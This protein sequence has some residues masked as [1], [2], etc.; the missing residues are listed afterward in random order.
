[1]K[2]K[3]EILNEPEG[4]IFPNPANDKITLNIPIKAIIELF[5]IEGQIMKTLITI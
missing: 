1:M 4:L 5:N 3:N 2:A